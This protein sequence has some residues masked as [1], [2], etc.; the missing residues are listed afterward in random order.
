MFSTKQH[1]TGRKKDAMKEIE[2][3]DPL[4]PFG[5]IIHQVHNDKGKVSSVMNRVGGKEGAGEEGSWETWKKTLPSQMLSKQS[6]DLATQQLNITYDRRKREFDEIMSLTNPTVR[7]DLLMKFADAT[8]AA[9]VHM[10]AAALPRQ[11]TRVILPIPSMK[12]TE[13]Y[14]PSYR[15]GE[16]VVLIRFPH[17]GTFE[18]PELT[19]NNRNREARRL[20]GTNPDDAV[21][22]HH[23]VAE[24]LSG[25]DFDGDT[26]LV[27]PN[28]RRSIKSTPALDGLKGFDPMV[29]K[30]PKDSP[31]HVW[32]VRKRA[33]RWVMFLI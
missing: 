7:K 26:V 22:I 1:D 29:Y 16:R 9:A 28:T 3:D 19:V 14:A 10:A 27:V 2:S 23:K 13:I 11:A 30:L 32:I 17:G 21:G 33:G 12:P 31:I 20:L 25:A 5:T 15:N 4:N 24:R 8:D 18:I 6:P